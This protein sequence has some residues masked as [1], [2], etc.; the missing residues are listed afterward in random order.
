MEERVTKAFATV[1]NL[2]PVTRVRVALPRDRR[3]FFF[4]FYRI[5]VLS[6]LRVSGL[7]EFAVGFA[8]SSSLNHDK[9]KDASPNKI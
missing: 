9:K 3:T 6:D 8:T 2:S 4:E 5:T 7:R 1:Y